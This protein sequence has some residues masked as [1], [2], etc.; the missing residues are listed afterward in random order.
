MDVTWMEI[1]RR[2]PRQMGSDRQ[3]PMM[4]GQMTG[5]VVLMHYA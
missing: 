2:A 1:P 5:R 4:F 3:Q